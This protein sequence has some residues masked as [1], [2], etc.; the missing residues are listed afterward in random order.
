[1]SIRSFAFAAILAAGMAQSALAQSGATYV[2]SRCNIFGYGVSTPA[3]SGGGGGMLAV[4]IPLAPGSGRTATFG[5]GGSAWWANSA[6]S[7]GPDGGTMVS[8]SNINAVGPI[9]GFAAP[10]CGELVGLFLAGDPTGMPAPANMSYPDAASLM[11]ASF[12]PQVQQ[13]F[14]IGDGLTGTGS[15]SQQVFSIPDGATTLVLGIADAF[16]F[17][18][19]AGWYDDNTGGYEVGYN[20]V[21]T[22]GSIALAGIGGLLVARRRR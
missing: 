15:G 6:G 20:V 1:M 11:A 5:A 22:P 13:V 10:R 16:G 18:G 4:V 14:F 7:N 9:S 17:A 21:P 8:A 12:S 19:N 2:D 3:P